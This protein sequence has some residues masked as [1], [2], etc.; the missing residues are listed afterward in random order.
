MSVPWL[1]DDVG[2]VILRAHGVVVDALDDRLRQ[3]IMAAL[4][5]QGT[6]TALGYIGSDRQIERGPT[7]TDQGYAAQLSAAFDT[8]RGAGGARTILNQM[9][10][11]YAPANGPTMRAVSDH[12]VWH[13]QD[14]V[15]GNVVKTVVI[16]SNWNWDGNARWWR[17]WVILQSTGQWTLDYW[18]LPGV[19]GD[20]GVWGSN[21]SYGE[22]Q[23]IKNILR[24]WKAAHNTDATIILTFDPSLFQ[25]SNLVAA[26]VNGQG[27]NYYWRALLLA[28]FSESI[29]T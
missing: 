14:P 7:Q 1:Q 21:M 18:N 19:W 11:Y 2:G 8:W 15:T 28:N 3:G 27:N 24:K 26:N 17:G 23:S 10:L 6:P 20:G 9:R 4:P 25:K 5:G 13:E 22:A 29:G 16:P 12:A